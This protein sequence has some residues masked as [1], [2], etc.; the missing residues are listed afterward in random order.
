MEK[1]WASGAIE[2][3]RHADSHIDLETAFD[4]RIAFISIDNCVETCIRTFLSLPQSKSGVK[5]TRSQLEDATNS[6]P[7]LLNLFLT[8]ASAR[9]SGIDP[10]DIEHYH[11]IRNT[12]YH[13][14]TGL[15]VDDQ[16][17]HAYRSIAVLLLQKLFGISSAQNTE[18]LGLDTLI[19]MWNRI[20]HLIRKKM[21]E[22]DID[23]SY[24][25]KWEEAFQAGILTPSQVEDL[26][27]LGIARNRLVHSQQVDEEDVTYWARKSAKLLAA[28]SGENE[29]GSWLT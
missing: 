1:T 4:K 17:L 15:S 16:Y 13:N 11:R 18:Q 23:T 3:L 27:E 10:Y 25:Y 20:Q 2:L 8:H 29:K 7:T 19:I 9:L 6:F 21:E 5:I 12:L 22:A 24:T 28:L 26:T 14:G